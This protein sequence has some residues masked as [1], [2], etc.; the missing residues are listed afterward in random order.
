M[1]FRW[2]RL[3]LSLSLLTLVVPMPP[4]QAS[5]LCGVAYS[6]SG[7]S[8]GRQKNFTFSVHNASRSTMHWVHIIPPSGLVTV[9]SASADGFTTDTSDGTATYDGGDLGSGATAIF[10]A[11]AEAGVDNGT[12][13]W[14]V[15]LS[16]NADLGLTCTGNLSLNVSAQPDDNVI[17]NVTV[18]NLSSTSVAI[19]WN[20]SAVSDS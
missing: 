10:S 12:G 3:L 8:P 9:Q 14:E 16:D 7:I 11:R 2:T 20:T 1:K 15:D 4:A 18:T 6:P 5:S 19:G 17:S 13:N